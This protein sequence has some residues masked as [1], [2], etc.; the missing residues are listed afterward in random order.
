MMLWSPSFA[1]GHPA[2]DRQHETLFQRVHELGL[3]VYQRHGEQE[4]RRTL[5]AASM[6]VEVHFSME[7]GLMREA[8]YP[9]LAAHQA[10]H[11]GLRAK[12]EEMVDRYHGAGLEA[13]DLLAFLEN[14]LTAHVLHEDREMAAF[15]QERAGDEITS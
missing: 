4:M 2:I 13:E 5:S 11:D 1:T 10:E 15:L 14:W 7:E 6:Y 9:G 3:A 12:V 8:G